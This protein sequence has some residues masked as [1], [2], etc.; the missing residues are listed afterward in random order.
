MEFLVKSVDYAPDDLYSQTPFRMTLL[1]QLPGP[2]RPDDWLAMLR[3]PI[4][5]K[6]SGGIRKIR[7]IRY[8]IICARWQG[9]RIEAGVKD[10]AIGIAYVLDPTQAADLAVNFRKV[11]Y[12]AIGI[13]DEGLG[14]GS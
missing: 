7:K 8:I 11:K 14:R 4:S 10:F 13:A 2:D 6:T 3:K 12:V 9:M 5:W 1:C